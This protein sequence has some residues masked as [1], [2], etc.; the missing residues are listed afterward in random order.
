MWVNMAVE[1]SFES[2]HRG[3]GM[4]SYQ[5]VSEVVVLIRVE[6]ISERQSNHLWVRSHCICLRSFR[7]LWPKHPGGSDGSETPRRFLGD[8]LDHWARGSLHLLREP[9]S[10]QQ[11]ECCYSE[12]S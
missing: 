6:W 7:S 12:K 1:A 9:S 2:H 3:G 8:M 11:T 5:L 4:G 10:G